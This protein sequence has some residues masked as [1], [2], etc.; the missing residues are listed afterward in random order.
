M[1][2]AYLIVFGSLIAFSAYI[3]LLSR[4]PAARASTYAY[5]N[6]VVALFLGWALADE[7]MTV[8]TGVAAGV[9]LSAVMLVNARTRRRL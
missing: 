4:V 8:Q 7:P 9:I 1:A 2:L 6:P 5:V 3:W